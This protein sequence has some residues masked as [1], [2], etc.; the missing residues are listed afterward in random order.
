MPIQLYYHSSRGSALLV[1]LII[2]ILVTLLTT[3][4]LEVIWSSSKNVQWIEASN[5]SYYQAIGIIEEQLIPANVTKK[6]PWNV[7]EISEGWFWY[8]TGRSILV[9]T[10]HTIMPRSGYGNSPYDPTKSYNLISLWEPVQIVIPN[11]II[12]NSVMFEFRVP[13]VSVTSWTWVAWIMANSWI[14][15]WTLWYTGASLYASWETQIFQW[16]DINTST[17]KFA[18]FSWITNSGSIVSLATF[19]IDPNY[20][21][22]WWNRCTNYACTLKLSMIR[23]I[24]TSDSIAGPQ[25]W[26]SLP[27]LE[28]KITF[29]T[30]VP[31]Q[32][33]TLD[34]SA[35]AYGFQRTRRVRIPQITTNTALDFAVLQ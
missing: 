17:N 18:S 10:G 30:T 28:Y 4:F 16:Q 32:F 27:F 23:P 2:L 35:Y 5:A 19:Y 12:W 9:Q 13:R 31:S 11:G 24:L 14:I 1:S 25:D 22:T 29:N 33:M 8:G 15:L 7:Q 6:T 34:A 20:L 3:V 26:R 21:D